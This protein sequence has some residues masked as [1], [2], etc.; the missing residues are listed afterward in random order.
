M[1][2]SKKAVLTKEL[3][4]CTV[5]VYEVGPFPIF[6]VDGTTD[7]NMCLSAVETL[8]HTDYPIDYDVFY[9]LVGRSGNDVHEFSG[10]VQ[11]TTKVV[12]DLEQYLTRAM[13][14]VRNELKNDAEW[15]VYTKLSS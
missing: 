6:V 1:L 3:L 8:F 4:G 9:F 7:M 11:T 5:N 14:S 12:G 2:L 10:A 13:F 15:D